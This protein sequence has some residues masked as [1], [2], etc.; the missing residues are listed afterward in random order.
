MAQ[1]TATQQP[2]VSAFPHLRG[3]PVAHPTGTP[4]QIEALEA[5]METYLAYPNGMDTRDG[6]M[7]KAEAILA[8]AIIVTRCQECGAMTHHR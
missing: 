1:A 4:E 2:T 6:N 5:R 7:T 8:G 3:C